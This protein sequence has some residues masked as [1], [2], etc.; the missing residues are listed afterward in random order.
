[1]TFLAVFRVCYVTISVHFRSYE[2]WNLFWNL[3]KSFFKFHNK[4]QIC[5]SAELK[6]TTVC[7]A[8]D[9]GHLLLLLFTINWEKNRKS[10]KTSK[11]FRCR[12]AFETFPGFILCDFDILLIYFFRN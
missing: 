10:L 11:I 7:T 5:S 12:A 4:N 2:F 6:H 8:S 3:K 9:F 1:M